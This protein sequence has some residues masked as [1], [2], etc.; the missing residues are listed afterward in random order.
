MSSRSFKKKSKGKGSNKAS[1]SASS[2]ASASAS[3]SSSSSA[4]SASSGFPSQPMFN[5]G[6][7]NFSFDPVQNVQAQAEQLLEQ[8]DSAEAIRLLRSHLFRMNAQPPKIAQLL[9][10][11]K[12][13]QA[14]LQA[15]VPL[16]PLMDL[17]AQALI[18]LDEGQMEA[19]MEEIDEEDDIL[20]QGPEA[21][22]FQWL[23]ASCALAPLASADK[24]MYLGQLTSGHDALK[25]FQQGLEIMAQQRNALIQKIQEKEQNQPAAATPN[26]EPTLEELKVQLVTLNDAMA[27]GMCS[28]VELFVTD[29]W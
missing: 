7:P 10:Q 9:A 13:A 12:A 16:T 28:Q 4:S 5:F 2:S 21:E 1:S 17:L 6:S 27:S 11:P 14:Q 19:L 24:W 22:A 15:L 18:N 29:L 3:A 20:N 23:Q 25:A 8:A 26:N